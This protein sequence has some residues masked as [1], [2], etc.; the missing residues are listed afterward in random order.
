MTLRLPNLSPQNPLRILAGVYV[1]DFSNNP[2]GKPSW[3]Q[4]GGSGRIR[5]DGG[6][7]AR[8]GDLDPK[9]PGVQSG[10]IFLTGL[11]ASVFRLNY[12]LQGQSWEVGN[13]QRT[14]TVEFDC[15]SGAE[16]P[17]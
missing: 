10:Q 1:L 12:I 16:L 2:S 11:G 3:S 14:T 15:H 5:Y 8:T 17:I 13:Q 9:Y 4:Q 6:F 7:V